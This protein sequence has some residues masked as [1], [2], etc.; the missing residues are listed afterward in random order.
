M[1]SVFVSSARTAAPVSNKLVW[2][3]RVLSGLVIAF[4]LFDGVIKLVPI[5]PVIEAS[6][7]LG[8]DPGLARSLGALLVTCTLL[9]VIPR[10]RVLGALLLTAYLGGATATHVR[11]GDPFFFPI[12]MGVILWAGLYLRE[13]RLRALL[14]AVNP[15]AMEN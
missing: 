15:K 2:T 7:R 1:E 8:W 11:I 5:A 13:P 3:G 4:L 9:H 6:Q 10:T 12:L 14:S